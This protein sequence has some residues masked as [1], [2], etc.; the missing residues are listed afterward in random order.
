MGDWKLVIN[1]SITVNDDDDQPTPAVES[2]NTEL[3]NLADD[4]SE[5][6]NLASSQ[7]EKVKELRARYEASAR[8]A[9]PP[10]SQ[11]KAKNF[12]VPKVWGQASS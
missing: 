2:P 1:G 12:R 3:F 7:P 10:K 8:Q 6:N 4:P 5:K 9:V 11:P